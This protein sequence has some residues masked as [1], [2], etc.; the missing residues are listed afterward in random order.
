MELNPN[1]ALLLNAPLT[2]RPYAFRSVWPPVEKFLLSKFLWSHTPH[3]GHILLH[4]HYKMWPKSR[5]WEHKKFDSK[6]FSTVREWWKKRYPT[7]EFM[8]VKE[9]WLEAG[10]KEGCEVLEKYEEGAK[11]CCAKGA[12]AHQVSSFTTFV[13]RLLLLLLWSKSYQAY[14]AY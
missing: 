2:T 13:S 7:Q 10:A 1:V 3:F 5:V 4:F 11:S 6:N 8:T 12:T 14:Q 9:L